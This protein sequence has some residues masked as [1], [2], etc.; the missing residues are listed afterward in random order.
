MAN[1][2]RLPSISGMV[3]D[4]IVLELKAANVLKEGPHSY[5]DGT[6]RGTAAHT[7]EH[8]DVK[9]E[10]VYAPVDA[11]LVL[12]VDKPFL[13]P[14]EDTE[15]A[16]QKILGVKSNIMLIVNQA[17]EA[18]LFGHPAPVPPMQQPGKVA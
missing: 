5:P 2:L 9:I 1:T 18:V 11:V 15:I 7:T 14:W 8:G 10:F 13:F 3:F 6:I 4:R 17:Q 16:G 12:N